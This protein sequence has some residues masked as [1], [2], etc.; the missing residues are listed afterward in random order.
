MVL[1]I[2]RIAPDKQIENAIE[3][4]RIMRVEALKDHDYCW[5]FALL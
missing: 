3:V 1:V 2:S 4:A 5:K